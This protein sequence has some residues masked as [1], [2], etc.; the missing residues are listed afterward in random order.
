MHFVFTPP[1]E[2][3]AG[4]LDLP[5]TVPLEDWDDVRL[6]EIRQ[7]GLSRHTVRFVAERP[8]AK[9]TKKGPGMRRAL[10]VGAITE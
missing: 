9:R 6:V 5:W 4:L 2:S 7:R 3:A 8:N 10:P 1:G